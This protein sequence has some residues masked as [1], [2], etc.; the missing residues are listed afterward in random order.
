MQ[1]CGATFN[2]MRPQDVQ[3]HLL[4]VHL[5][6]ALFC[7][8]PGCHWRCWH[9]N[10]YETH[11]NNVHPGYDG[12]QP[13]EIYDRA[14]IL[15]YIRN[16]AAFQ[17]AENLALGFVSERAGELG[18]EEEWEDLCGRRAIAGWCRCDD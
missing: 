1:G 5:P 15:G 16:G 7:T 2:P 8:I 18:K 12:L 9:E 11:L 10:D 17:T 4:A 14:L 13:G 3:Y 6:F